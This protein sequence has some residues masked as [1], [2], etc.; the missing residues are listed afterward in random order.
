MV[1]SLELTQM[2]CANCTSNGLPYLHILYRALTFDLGPWLLTATWLQWGFNLW[3]NIPRQGAVF[4]PA[5]LGNEG[6][7]YKSVGPSA[8]WNVL[9]A[10][11]SDRQA[12]ANG[13]FY[14]SHQVKSLVFWKQSW[15]WWWEWGGGALCPFVVVPC[16]TRYL[17]VLKRVFFMRI[18]PT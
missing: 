12:R 9:I 16:H 8:S 10:Q 14:R 7:F 5:Q 4:S 2:H 6:N 18:R 17:T 13:I 15:W 1:Y 3:W 11:C